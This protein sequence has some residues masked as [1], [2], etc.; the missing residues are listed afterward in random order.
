MQGNYDG[1]VRINTVNIDKWTMMKINLAI[2]W[3]ATGLLEHLLASFTQIP[4]LTLLVY[5]D[6]CNI[7]D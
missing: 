5:C 1:W 7:F 2:G 3:V 4:V 6:Y